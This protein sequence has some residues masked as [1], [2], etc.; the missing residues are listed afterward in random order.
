MPRYKTK[1]KNHSKTYDRLVPLRHC[2]L[3]L[4]LSQS[5]MAG[6]LGMSVRKYKGL[7]TGPPNDVPIVVELAVRYLLVALTKKQRENVHNLLL[8]RLE[9]DPPIIS[10]KLPKKT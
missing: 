1:L 4:E 2:R 5:A 10:P 7:E 6:T 9:Q 8:R 3:L